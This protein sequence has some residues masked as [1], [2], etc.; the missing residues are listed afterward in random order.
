MQ[1]TITL[2]IEGENLCFQQ[3]DENLNICATKYI[4]KGEQIRTN[5]K[6][7]LNRWIYK[8][9][10]DSDD[11]EENFDRFLDMFLSQKDAL[12]K[13]AQELNVSINVYITS[14]QAQFGYSLTKRQLD[15]LNLLGVDVHFHIFS[16]GMI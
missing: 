4:S 12:H 15:Q 9:K 1:G 16:Y 6:S 13:I 8:K 2:T 3:L 14:E 10:F 7:E 5:H 11:F